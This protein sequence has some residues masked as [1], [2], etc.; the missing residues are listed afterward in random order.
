LAETQLPFAINTPRILL[1]EKAGRLC[2]I[3][4]ERNGDG[5]QALVKSAAVLSLVSAGD[6]KFDLKSLR[7]RSTCGADRY[8]NE[9]TLKNFELVYREFCSERRDAPVW[10]PPRFLSHTTLMRKRSQT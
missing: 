10:E 4:W 9:K 2:R 1:E 7:R 3:C 5:N 8:A 6:V